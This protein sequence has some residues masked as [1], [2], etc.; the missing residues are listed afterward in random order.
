MRNNAQIYYNIKP[1]VFD[2]IIAD[3]KIL[4]Y[5]NTKRKYEAN[6]QVAVFSAFY[7]EILGKEY[8]PDFPVD[9]TIVNRIMKVLE[10]EQVQMQEFLTFA[11]RKYRRKILLLGIKAL[12][13]I[14]QEYLKE[15]KCR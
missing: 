15:R 12:P 4:S 2:S 5:R 8:F 1:E 3:L 10:Q 14:L 9:N 13:S 7:L 6:K 11:F